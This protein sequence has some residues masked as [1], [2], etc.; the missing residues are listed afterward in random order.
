VSHWKPLHFLLYLFRLQR[1]KRS[2]PWSL[3]TRYVANKSLLA[4]YSRIILAFVISRIVSW[5][6]VRLTSVQFAKLV[7][8]SSLS[9]SDSWYS[10][11]EQQSVNKWVFPSTSLHFTAEEL[12]R[13][14]GFPNL[15]VPAF[16]RVSV[17][18]CNVCQFST[19]SLYPKVRINDK[20]ANKLPG[21]MVCVWVKCIAENVGCI[22]QLILAVYFF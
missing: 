22:G 19:L 14:I 1:L 21:G 7:S 10:T 6:S 2:F 5:K 13:S 11:S 18:A 3:Y 20:M 17:L 9:I 16:V 15:C 8:P 12:P 4:A